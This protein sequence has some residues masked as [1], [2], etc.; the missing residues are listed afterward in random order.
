MTPLKTV[1]D[2]RKLS[3]STVII[4]HTAPI[5]ASPNESLYFP[6]VKNNLSPTSPRPGVIIPRSVTFSSMPATK[7]STPSGH[8]FAA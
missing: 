1:Q 5:R 6:I 2:I 7:I 3:F 4:A 8:S